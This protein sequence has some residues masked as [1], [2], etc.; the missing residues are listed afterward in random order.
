V[1][2]ASGRVMVD[3]AGESLTAH[4]I[5]RLRHPSVGAVILF[6]RNFSS[7]AQLCGLIGQIRHSREDLLVAVDHEG[8]RVQRFRHDGFTPL[9]AMGRLGKRFEAS[10]RR[11]QAE[12]ARDAHA[13][14]YVMA[15]ELRSVGIDFSFA[16]VLD[17]DFGRS[18]VIGDRAFSGDPCVT[19]TLARAL[20]HGMMQGGMA[21]CGKHFPGHGFA[22]ADSHVAMP[23]DERDLAAILS[24]DIAPYEWL[25]AALQSVMPAHV[26][27]PKI[28]PAPAGFSSVWLQRILRGQLA[29]DG[30]ILSDDLSMQGAFIAG[31]IGARALAALNAGCDMVLVCNQPE[32]AD[33]LL[34]ELEYPTS[35]D[36]HR[37]LNALRGTTPPVPLDP[38]DDPAYERCLSLIQQR[39]P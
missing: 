23:E 2:L 4:E 18:A 9:P 11:D 3:V 34:L 7:R 38:N 32:E 1:K 17:L 27:Y 39:Y 15:R 19:E 12:V 10:S 8:G 24:N 36:S 22:A 30:A 37:R 35:S 5:G 28:D 33:R 31:D 29:F 13:I 20:L 21:N 14:G 25:G 26:I 6:A 16:P